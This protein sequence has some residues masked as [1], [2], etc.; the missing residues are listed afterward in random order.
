M[1]PVSST[2]WSPTYFD[3]SPWRR[4][5]SASSWF[6]TRSELKLVHP[7]SFTSCVPLVKVLPT[8]LSRNQI[9]HV[10]KKNPV[11]GGNIGGVKENG[12][13]DDIY[14]FLEAAGNSYVPLLAQGPSWG[15][16]LSTDPS[17]KNV[18]FNETRIGGITEQ[19]VFHVLCDKEK[20]MLQ[21]VD[22]HQRV[23]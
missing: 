22:A 16:G 13:I 5:F 4:W 14:Q 20:E 3:I 2:P 15:P 12:E 19:E 10:V 21:I 23:L 7:Q 18:I 8:V 1:S 17:G 11:A 6:K 9:R